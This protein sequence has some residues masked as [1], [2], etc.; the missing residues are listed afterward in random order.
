M[1]TP[2]D[3]LVI[4]GIGTMILCALVWIDDIHKGGQK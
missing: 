1:M 4:I 2:F 3:M